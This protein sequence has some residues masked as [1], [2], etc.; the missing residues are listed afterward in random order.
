VTI[1]DRG[2]IA[3]NDVPRGHPGG[4]IFTVGHAFLLIP[5]CADGNEGCADAPLDP[6][7]VARSRVVSGTAPKTMTAEALAKFK[8]RIARMHAGM[9]HRNR[10]LGTSPRD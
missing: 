7:V 8:E 6:A 3:G 9:T 1:N 4:D 2:E 5:V 10:G